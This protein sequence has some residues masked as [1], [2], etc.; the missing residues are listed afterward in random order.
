MNEHN[1]ESKTLAEEVANIQAPTDIDSYNTDLNGSEISAALSQEDNEKI[2]ELEEVLNEV[3][4][5]KQ[6]QIHRND[7][8]QLD[9]TGLGDVS[10]KHDPDYPSQVTIE[11]NIP[12]TE[13]KSMPNNY[14]VHTISVTRE[15]DD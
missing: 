5:S 6:G 11:V 3:H 7:Q 14:G 10:V 9:S 1:K 12:T 4:I 15:I 8:K 13:E 2:K